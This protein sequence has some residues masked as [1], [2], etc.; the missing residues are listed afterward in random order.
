M[1]SLKKAECEVAAQ[2]RPVRS[3][4]ESRVFFAK[5]QAVWFESFSSKK[6]ERLPWAL[7]FFVRAKIL[8]RNTVAVAPFMGV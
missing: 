5:R 1:L 3:E 2:R 7:L 8:F 4:R 6:E